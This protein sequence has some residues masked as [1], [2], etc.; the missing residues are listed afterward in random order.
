M[1]HPTLDKNGKI[2]TSA[3]T[4]LDLHDFSRLARTYGLGGVYAQTNLP[5]QAA[6]LTRLLSHWVEGYG[7]EYNPNRKEA[8][9]VLEMV[10]S[11]EEA[12]DRV[13]EKWGA[14]PLVAVTSARLD[15]PPRL[16]YREVSQRL[17]E[18]ARPSLILFGTGWGLAPEVLEKCDFVIEPIGSPSGYNHLSVR[19]AASITVDRLFG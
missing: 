19:S 14:K 3:I 13:E 6:L 16:G 11:L 2:I 12:A 17:K 15:G 7:A 18:E 9:S 8:L 5:Q 1:H 10:S 4:A